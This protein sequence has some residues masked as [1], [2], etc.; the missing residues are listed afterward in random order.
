MFFGRYDPL[1][2][3]VVIY[4]AGEG[5]TAY[6]GSSQLASVLLRR[7]PREVRPMPAPLRLHSTA[8]PLPPRPCACGC[9][10]VFVPR[11]GDQKFATERCRNRVCQRRWT[12]RNRDLARARNARW[13]ARRR[14]AVSD[15]RISNEAA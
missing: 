1:P 11:R 14:E 12:E 9:G 3:S 6:R 5:L 13:R 7:A 8:P 10:D 15:S 2:A 4:Q